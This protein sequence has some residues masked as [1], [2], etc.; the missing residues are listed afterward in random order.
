MP[1]WVSTHMH[2]RNGLVLLLCGTLGK[3]C[4]ENALTPV[5]CCAAMSSPALHFLLQASQDRGLLTSGGSYLPA[6]LLKG[7]R[8]PGA[9]RIPH[10]EY[11][12]PSGKL[13]STSVWD[14]FTFSR[15][16]LCGSVLRVPTEWVCSTK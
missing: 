10:S 1:T 8:F 7:T 5:W 12:K 2:L 11:R 15:H 13:P 3:G 14:L 6:V 16:P 4:P 9:L